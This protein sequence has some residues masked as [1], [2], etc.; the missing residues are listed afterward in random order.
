MNITCYFIVILGVTLLIILIMNFGNRFPR[1]GWRKES[2]VGNSIAWWH[3]FYGCEVRWRFHIWHFRLG[4]NKTTNWG[5]EEW[6]VDLCHRCRTGENKSLNSM[7][8]H[9]FMNFI[10][11]QICHHYPDMRKGSCNSVCNNLFYIFTIHSFFLFYPFFISPPFFLSVIC[12]V[13]EHWIKLHLY[14]SD[15]TAWDV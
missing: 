15:G 2:H 7:L 3:S 13:L 14:L 11:L 12:C 6:L 4:S 10:L 8:W 1:R 9:H 5:R